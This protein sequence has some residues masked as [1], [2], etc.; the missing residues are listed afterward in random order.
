M[1]ATEIIINKNNEN[2]NIN[3]IQQTLLALT[4]SIPML[5]SIVSLHSLKLWCFLCF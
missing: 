1:E 2:T 4:K 3:T 5:T